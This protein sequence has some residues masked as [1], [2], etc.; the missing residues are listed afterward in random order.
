MY[1]NCQTLR[2]RFI[3]HI[4]NNANDHQSHSVYTYT[5]YRT[6]I[7]K[8][9]RNNVIQ[10]CRTMSAPLI[11]KVILWFWQR[12]LHKSNVYDLIILLNKIC[13]LTTL[14]RPF[15][16]YAAMEKIKIKLLEWNIMLS[17]EQIVICIV[18]YKNKVH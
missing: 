5:S 9:T 14:Q 15:L 17:A 2:L 7:V 1:M 12:Q 11:L 10:L 3:Q 18:K 8:T 13:N 4:L 6:A 16:C